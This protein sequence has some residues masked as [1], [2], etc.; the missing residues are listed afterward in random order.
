MFAALKQ[1][2]Q[3]RIEM[4]ARIPRLVHDTGQKDP[5]PSGPVDSRVLPDILPGPEG[6]SGDFARVNDIQQAVKAALV[7]DLPMSGIF[8]A[9]FRVHERLA[10]T[11]ILRRLFEFLLVEVVHMARVEIYSVD[12]E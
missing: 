10:R 5:V 11:E 7:H 1:P 9:P 12:V 2:A 3:I 8:P 4:L 6:V